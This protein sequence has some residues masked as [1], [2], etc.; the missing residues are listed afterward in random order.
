MWLSIEGIKGEKRN[1][2]GLW[3]RVHCNGTET[4]VSKRMSERASERVKERERESKG[5]AR[6]YGKALIIEVDTGADASAAARSA[7][8][9]FRDYKVR[10]CYCDVPCVS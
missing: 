5:R 9:I 1:E 7:H 10:T 8:Q 4:S 6:T 3:N 2:T